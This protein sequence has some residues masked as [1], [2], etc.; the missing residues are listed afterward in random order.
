MALYPGGV[1]AKVAFRY[2]KEFCDASMSRGF[3]E[4]VCAH[5]KADG[6]DLKEI[7]LLAEQRAF[8]QKF[9]Y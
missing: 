4:A 5:F 1:H 7:P 9:E 6:I 2:P 3:A 8:V